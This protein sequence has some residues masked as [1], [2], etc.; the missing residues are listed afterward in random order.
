LQGQALLRARFSQRARH[1][2]PR[3]LRLPKGWQRGNEKRGAKEA[4][5]SIPLVHLR[6][7][8]GPRP[9]GVGEAGSGRGNVRG[10][11][12]GIQQVVGQGRRPGRAPAG[13]TAAGHVSEESE[14]RT[15]STL[16]RVPLP[17]ATPIL[18]VY[19]ELLP[20]HAAG[21]REIRRAEGRF[22]GRPQGAPLSPVLEGRIRPGK[23][24][25]IS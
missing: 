18:Q 8:R 22:H 14:H 16:P 10:A 12:G 7:V 13:L 19:T 4:Q 3:A 2:A 17:H 11:A 5:R 1:S 6:D 15:Y 23:M 21:H 24:S 25:S 20:L 9:R